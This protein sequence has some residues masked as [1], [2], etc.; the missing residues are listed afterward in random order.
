[1]KSW[2]ENNLSERMLTD[3]IAVQYLSSKFK[4][5]KRFKKKK[6]DQVPW[7]WGQAAGGA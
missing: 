3:E 7:N 6:R 5:Q 1:M 4:E 2:K